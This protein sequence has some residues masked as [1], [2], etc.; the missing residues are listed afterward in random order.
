MATIS[1]K[2]KDEKVRAR[3][4]KIMKGTADFSEPLKKC[5]KE[6]IFITGRNFDS[7]GQ[8]FGGWQPLSP[9]TIAAKI[10]LGF[11]LAPLVAT[12]EMKRSFKV[13]ERNKTR[14]V[15]GN[16]TKYYPYHQ[17]G[18][19]KI[20]QRRM[21]GASDKVKDMVLKTFTEHIKKLLK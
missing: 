4:D 3:L 2:I 9:I 8:D 17:V 1:I 7:R 15:I 16:Q 20:P 12:G 11:P 6:A 10:K 19:G 18:T 13:L 14:V 5:G 21:L